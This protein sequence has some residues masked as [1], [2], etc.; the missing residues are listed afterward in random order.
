MHLRARTRIVCVI[1]VYLCVAGILQTGGAIEHRNTGD[2]DNGHG[3]VLRVTR[4]VIRF[5]NNM[6][7]EEIAG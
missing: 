5:R 7:S 6:N 3:G 1:Y 2:M 4:K